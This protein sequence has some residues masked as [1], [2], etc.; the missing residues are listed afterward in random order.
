M[1]SSRVRTGSVVQDKR[2]KVWRFFWWESGK[3]RSKKLGR[4]CQQDGSYSG[5]R[6]VVRGEIRKAPGPSC[7]RRAERDGV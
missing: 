6:K 1:R 7:F 5:R 4:V 2:D 3:R